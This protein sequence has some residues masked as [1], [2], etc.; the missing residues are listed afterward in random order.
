M[1]DFTMP[2]IMFF[3]NFPISYARWSSTPIFYQ[4]QCNCNNNSNN[5][6]LNWWMMSEMVKNIG[7]MFRRP[8]KQPPIQYAYNNSYQQYTQPY[9]MMYP[10]VNFNNTQQHPLTELDEGLRDLQEAYKDCKMKYNF[11]KVNDKYIAIDNDGKR[12]KADT[13]EELMDKIDTKINGKDG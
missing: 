4:Q 7:Q 12:I 9:Q 5:Q 3:S 2:P 6:W 13:V 11:V 8:E 10:Y 1:E